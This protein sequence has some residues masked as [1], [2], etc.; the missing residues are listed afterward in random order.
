MFVQ[1]KLLLSFSAPAGRF[2]NE[3]RPRRL[4]WNASLQNLCV[5]W[6]ADKCSGGRLLKCVLLFSPAV[7]IEC[8][9]M[10]VCV[11]LYRSTFQLRFFSSLHLFPDPSY[12]CAS[13]LANVLEIDLDL[14]KVGIHLLQNVRVLLYCRDESTVFQK[15]KLSLPPGV[16]PEEK[17]RERKKVDLGNMAP[18]ST[19]DTDKTGR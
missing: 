11:C 2:C 10:C 6:W 1:L 16:I 18:L 13:Q 8:K 12:P 9:W 3:P 4:L 14:V 5:H 19:I 7:L 15:R 17:G